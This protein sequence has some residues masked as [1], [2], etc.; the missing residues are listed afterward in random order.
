M[1]KCRYTRINTILQFTSL[2]LVSVGVH[3]SLFRFKVDT[4]L[5]ASMA[6]FVYAEEM[7]LI[8]KKKFERKEEDAGSI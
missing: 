3:G 8:I 5:S 2:Y 4:A 1:E 6:A 7:L